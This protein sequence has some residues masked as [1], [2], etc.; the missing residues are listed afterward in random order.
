MHHAVLSRNPQLVDFL[1]HIL[2]DNVMRILKA[3]DKEGDTPSDLVY[4][5][6]YEGWG[7]VLSLKKIYATYEGREKLMI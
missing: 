1:A 2:R 7:V 4:K 5:P 6:G 3:K